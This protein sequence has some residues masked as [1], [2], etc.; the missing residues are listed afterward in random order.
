MLKTKCVTLPCGL[1]AA[2]VVLPRPAL[3]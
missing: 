3:I 1:K 2:S